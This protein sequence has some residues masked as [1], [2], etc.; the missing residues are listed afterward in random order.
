MFGKHD[1]HLQKSF[2]SSINEL[3]P[4]AQEALDTGWAGVFYRECFCMLDEMPF[5]TL[6]SN[7]GS[8]PNTPVNILLSF[9]IIKAGFGWSDIRTHRAF[10]YDLEV[11]YAVGWCNL[12]KG[13]FELRT[14]YNFR[15][16]L[17]EHEAKTGENLLDQAFE[18]VTDKQLRKLKL[19]TSQVRMDSTMISSNIRYLSRLELLVTTLGCVHKMLSEQDKAS[20]KEL[21][22]DYVRCDSS[23][24][25]QK[26]PS[27]EGHQRIQE[28]GTVMS[29][30]VKEL[31]T[32][33]GECHAYKILER[34]YN[35]HFVKESDGTRPR[36]PDEMP[37]G[38]VQTPHDEDATMRTKR[39]VKNIGY[40]S[41]LIE[42]CAE[43]N[44][45]QLVVGVQTEPNI[46]SDV[47]MLRE[48]LESLSRRLGLTSIWTDGGYNSEGN[49]DLTSRLDIAHHQTGIQG[50]SSRR[51]LPLADYM[52]KQAED[53]TPLSVVCP[54]GIEVDVKKLP[55]GRYRAYYDLNGCASCPH[56]AVCL[57]T[58][59]K[60]NRAL[61]FDDYQI[62]LARR[63][64]EIRELRIKGKNPRAAAESTVYAHKRRFG[65]KLPVR[66][67]FRVRA[68][69]LGAA[70]MFNIRRITRYRR[71][72]Q[73]A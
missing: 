44:P 58:L 63:R 21:L 39:R 43:D 71:S 51:R 9:E 41:N 23:H 25:V 73:A 46:T 65:R 68:L 15:K 52:I 38:T 59:Q 57:A 33:Y 54:N 7:V 61:G 36:T 66:G 28:I 37:K 48:K 16:R 30:L 11:R 42:T 64:L 4:N 67:L 20:Y 1:K 10:T 47:R 55:S 40:T 24:Y 70:F 2:N 12:A 19:N 22:H 26:V 31:A 17:L 27:G 50:S 62:E 49:F 56:A 6:Y 14:V 53:G 29:Q 13:H 8:R 5:A 72:L 60:T 34:I 3:P 45:V 18:Q 32:N 35:E 69:M